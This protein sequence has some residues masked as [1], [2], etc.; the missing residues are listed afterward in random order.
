MSA[1]DLRIPEKRLQPFLAHHRLPSAFR[2]TAVEYY[3]PLAGKLPSLRAADG[4][5]LLG[6]NGAQG[7]GKSTLADFLE[8]AAHHLFG[9]CT[10]VLSID[11]F[12]LTHDERLAMARDVHPL[13]ATRGVP[14]THD[15]AMLADALDRLVDLGT[16]DRLRLP[17]F[18]KA[19]DDR[20][21]N[22]TWPVV[23]GPLDVIVL[24]G[25]CVGSEAQE[26][27]L[28]LEAVNELERDEDPDGVWR[29]TVNDKLGRD[30]EPLFARLDALAYLRA[31]SFDAIFRWRCEQER[32]LAEASSST[33]SSIMSGEQV[34]RF[35]SY[36]ERLTRHNLDTLPARADAVL[37]LNE[38][39][40]VVASD[41]KQD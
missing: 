13:F 5:L 38:E 36:Y 15:T 16:G 10:A 33:A 18:D 8:M 7:T 11:D 28:L 9:W 1:K 29:R 34:A 22:S 37:T 39:H 26:Q 40:A 23:E 6:I 35:I 24:E 19:N 32:K 12:Y 4:P 30:Y 20:A 17:R 31:P 21:E 3:L 27:R 25:W 41:W 14:G 2:K